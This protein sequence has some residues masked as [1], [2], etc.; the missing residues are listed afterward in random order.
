MRKLSTSTAEISSGDRKETIGVSRGVVEVV[1]RK[2]GIRSHTI[3]QK[4]KLDAAEKRLSAKKE[5]AIAMAQLQ[6]VE[7]EDNFDFLYEPIESA[8]VIQEGT[9]EFV[10]NQEP[11]VPPQK[12][13]E[14]EPAP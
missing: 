2:G 10:R 3:L 14:E 12:D 1:R 7:K 8:S 13:L 9:A 5:A 11:I 6:G 4:T